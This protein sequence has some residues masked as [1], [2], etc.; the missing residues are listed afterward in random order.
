MTMGCLV[1]RTA[2]G[3]GRLNDCITIMILEREIG[4]DCWVWECLGSVRLFIVRDERDLYD[5]LGCLMPL[6]PFQIITFS[7][8]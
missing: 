8:M 5:M 6:C 2:F 4:T 3:L 1:L 7:C